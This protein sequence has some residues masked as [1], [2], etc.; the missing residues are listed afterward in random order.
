MQTLQ[1]VR[2]LDD[3]IQENKDGFMEDSS[4]AKHLGTHSNSSV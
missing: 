2:L 3:N 1:Q 4:L